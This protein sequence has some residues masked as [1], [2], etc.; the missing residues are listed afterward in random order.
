MQEALTRHF[1][2]TA[3]RERNAGLA[4]DDQMTQQGF[5]NVIGVDLDTGKCLLVS[6]CSVAWRQLVGGC[7][8]ARRLLVGG[9]DVARRQLVG[10]CSVAR[11]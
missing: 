8:V 9:W 5:D 3:F 11:R 6:G 2:G 1:Q 10:G 7:G 4:I